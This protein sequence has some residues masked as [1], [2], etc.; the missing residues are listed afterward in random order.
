MAAEVLQ[1]SSLLANLP[2]SNMVVRGS[3]QCY[4]TN[5]R[6]RAVQ[7]I[8]CCDKGL[9]FSA[10]FCRCVPWN[11]G[12]NSLH[13]K[14]P[15]DLTRDQRNPKLSET[16][17]V[18]QAVV[19]IQSEIQQD[20]T[21]FPE[22]VDQGTPQLPR[23]QSNNNRQPQ[24]RLNGANP[25]LRPPMPRIN[26][27]NIQQGN[28]MILRMPVIHV[29]SRNFRNQFVRR[30][31][32][33]YTIRNGRFYFSA[34]IRQRYPSVI[35]RI[36]QLEAQGVVIKPSYVRPIVNGLGIPTESSPFATAAGRR[37][38]Q[39]PV[40]DR[41]TENTEGATENIELGGN[42]PLAQ[43]PDMSFPTTTPPVPTTEA[44]PTVQAKQKKMPNM[45]EF[46]FVLTTR[47]GHTPIDAIT[48]LPLNQRFPENF[49]LPTFEPLPSEQPLEQPPPSPPSD[50][51]T[52]S[53]PSTA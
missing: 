2:C 51:L 46:P 49:V 30:A 38:K 43:T 34:L 53:L 47:G 9:M 11:A 32:P 48:G 33:I 44:I 23:V 39:I 31:F 50:L 13:A 20:A 1:L 24:Y 35:G 8:M 21:G 42:D 12:I 6:Q 7:R 17:D 15:R 19:E 52:S 37:Q 45:N 29:V 41:M 14:I 28:G 40:V 25:L 36:R 18:P 26:F 22:R 27:M 5:I 3:P 10:E 4:Y 16:I